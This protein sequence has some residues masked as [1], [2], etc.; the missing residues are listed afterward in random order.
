MGE[1]VFA[2]ISVEAAAHGVL[3]QASLQIEINATAGVLELH[4]YKT[5]PMV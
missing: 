1:E 3:F 2:T 4:L 5:K